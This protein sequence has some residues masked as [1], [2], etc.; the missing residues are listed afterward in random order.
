MSLN[1]SLPLFPMSLENLAKIYVYSSSTRLEDFHFYVSSSPLPST[2]KSLLCTPSSREQ[3]NSSTKKV[4]F[5][6]IINYMK[7]EGER[8]K[9][10]NRKTLELPRLSRETKS[11]DDD[12]DDDENGRSGVRWWNKS[13]KSVILLS[14][15]ALPSSSHC[16]VFN[17]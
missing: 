14:S 16:F 1:S 8:K 17:K 15:Y 5:K 12:N 3:R 6:A 13:R 11:D 9:H 2:L 10:K 7:D 4:N